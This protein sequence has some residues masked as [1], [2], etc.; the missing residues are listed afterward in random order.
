MDAKELQALQER[1]KF[2]AP[3]MAAVLGVPY[4]QYRHFYFGHTKIPPQVERAAR[5]LELINKTFMSDR[6]APGGSFDQELNQLYP[7]GIMSEPLPCE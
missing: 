4:S 2:D 6:Y 1:V 3:S 7:Q 5:E